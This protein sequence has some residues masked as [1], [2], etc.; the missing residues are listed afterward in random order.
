MT[1]SHEE[2]VRDHLSLWLKDSASLQDSRPRLTTVL[3][4]AS[5]G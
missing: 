4:L 5:H 3:W 2:P 1:P